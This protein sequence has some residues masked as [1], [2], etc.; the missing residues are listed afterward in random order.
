V[1]CDKIVYSV[2][3]CPAEL[4]NKMGLGLFLEGIFMT[5]IMF[6]FR[7]LKPGRLI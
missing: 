6:D 1:F 2:L 4:R 5:G 7:F 3:E